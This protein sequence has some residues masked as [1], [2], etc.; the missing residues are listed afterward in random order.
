MLTNL[1]LFR[2]STAGV[3]SEP[4]QRIGADSQ[5]LTL[6]DRKCDLRPIQIGITQFGPPFPIQVQRFDIPDENGELTIVEQR[7]YSHQF[8]IEDLEKTERFL[9]IFID[10]Q[11]IHY[12]QYRADHADP[13]T[14]RIFQAVGERAQ[15]DRVDSCLS[16]AL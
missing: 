16:M 6:N 13:L 11:M 1:I 15:N 10:N 2:T 3:A 14:M 4:Y 12:I 7:L 9:N 5:I 8:C